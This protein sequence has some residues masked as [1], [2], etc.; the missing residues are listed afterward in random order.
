MWNMENIVFYTSACLWLHVYCD[1]SPTSGSICWPVLQWCCG[2]VWS[3]HCMQAG[4]IC[5]WQCPTSGSII[6]YML[7]C[8]PMMLW[9]CLVCS[10]HTSWSYLCLAMHYTQCRTDRRFQVRLCWS[11]RNRV[12][13]KRRWLL[14][15]ACKCRRTATIYLRL[16]RRKRTQ[17]ILVWI[18]TSFQI[19][20]WDFL[21]PWN[22]KDRLTRRNL[23]FGTPRPSS[24]HCSVQREEVAESME[25]PYQI[26]HSM[27]KPTTRG[28]GS[29]RHYWKIKSKENGWID[30]DL[31]DFSVADVWSG[32]VD[33]YRQ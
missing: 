11:Y 2:H 32:F 26:L 6:I 31:D 7:A 4:P 25:K 21:F 19:F 15:N 12:A 14:A 16:S 27:N 30:S 13:N 29:C 17:E 18:W 1:H 23:I 20:A 28:G 10:L 24:H 22:D 5:V 9:T 8:A 33:M 3:A